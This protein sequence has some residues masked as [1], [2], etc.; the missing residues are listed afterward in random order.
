[1]V[2]SWDKGRGSPGTRCKK[3][4]YNLEGIMLKRSCRSLHIGRDTQGAPA[5]NCLSLPR[6]G[7]GHVSE[8]TFEMV[9]STAHCNLMRG[10]KPKMPKQAAP[11]LLAHKKIVRE[12]DYCF[13]MLLSFGVICYSTVT[14]IALNL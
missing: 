5:S 6:P 4:S 13:F 11:K 7:A 2:L 1:M 10:H 3:S 8:K 14:R 12:N 9:P